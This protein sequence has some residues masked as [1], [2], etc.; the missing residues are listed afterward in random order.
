MLE[1]V[2]FGVVALLMLCGVFMLS[3]SIIGVFRFR[4]VLNRM[5]PASVTDTLG[6]MMVVL[7]LMVAFGLDWATL[8][9]ALMIVFVWM[10]SP[11]SAHLLS[12]LEVTTGSD[13]EQHLIIV[14]KT[15]GEKKA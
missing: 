7:A 13:V 14:D 12:K 6:L 8:K 11:I 15:E 2:R 4:Y 5:H 10:A 3:V 1:W 9:L